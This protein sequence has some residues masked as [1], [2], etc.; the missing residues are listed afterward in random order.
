MYL[1][2]Y[3]LLISLFEHITF[4]CFR[5][6]F[7]RG[8]CTGP[9]SRKWPKHVLGQTAVR[10][11]EEDLAL[12]YQILMFTKDC[13]QIVFHSKESDPLMVGP[14]KQNSLF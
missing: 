9:G 6:D 12:E 4:S 1:F 5:S 7:S 2:T 11:R 3:S 14:K 8:F 10:L 13:K